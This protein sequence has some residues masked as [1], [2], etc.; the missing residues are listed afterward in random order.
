MT[1]G[2]A[3]G[4]IFL[5]ACFICGAVCCGGL[6]LALGIAGVCIGALNVVVLPKTQ[7][8][9]IAPHTVGLWTVQCVGRP[10]ENYTVLE[11]TFPK[12]PI[13]GVSV[14]L[15]HASIPHQML[16]IPPLCSAFADL[17]DTATPWQF[18]NADVCIPY[19]SLSWLIAGIAFLVLVVIGFVSFTMIMLQREREETR[20]SRTDAP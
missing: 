18:T 12:P 11:S 1:V 8:T 3:I 10:G 6:F 7:C 19:S 5:K 14:D 4:G 15:V 16:A 20:S 9:L 17:N 13:V 2:N